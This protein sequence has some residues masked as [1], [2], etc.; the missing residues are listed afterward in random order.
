[1][2]DRSDPDEH[3]RDYRNERKWPA[4]PDKAVRPR[5]MSKVEG[6]GSSVERRGPEG[7]GKVEGL[8]EATQ[9]FCSPMQ[10]LSFD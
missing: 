4:A 8:S 5:P 10:P 3:L 2:T 1:M 7:G 9:G 6:R